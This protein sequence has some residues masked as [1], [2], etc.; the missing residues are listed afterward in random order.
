MEE[1]DISKAFNLFIEKIIEQFNELGSDVEIKSKKL[2][3]ILDDKKIKDKKDL[4][5]SNGRYYLNEEY[6]DC[7][8]PFSDSPGVYLFFNKDGEAIYVGK[9]EVKIG[10]RIWSH[11]GPYKNGEYRYLEFEEAEYVIVIPFINAPFMAPSFESYLSK[12]YDFKYNKN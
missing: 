10:R 9:C 4:N 7:Y 11:T 3:F 6:K 1:D 2:T 5:T 12:N 8:F